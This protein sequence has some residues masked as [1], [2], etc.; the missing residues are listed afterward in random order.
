MSGTQQLSLQQQLV[1][2]ALMNQN[3]Q[4]PGKMDVT[5][6]NPFENT[7]PASMN[8]PYGFPANLNTRGASGL[9]S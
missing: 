1:L 2:S 3:S 5:G 4:F 9:N 6:K 7:T 8:G